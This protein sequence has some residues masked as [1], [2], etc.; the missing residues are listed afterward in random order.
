MELHDDNAKWNYMMIM[1]NG[2]LDNE[3]FNCMM[4]M[5]G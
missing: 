2:L 5:K 4:I 1:K 3:Q